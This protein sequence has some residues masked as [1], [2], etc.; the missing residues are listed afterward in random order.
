MSGLVLC[1]MHD[2]SFEYITGFLEYLKKQGKLNLLNEMTYHPYPPIP[3]ETYPLADRLRQVL[4]DYSPKITIKHG[5]TGCPAEFNK[6]GALAGHDWTEISQAKWLLRRMCGDY[7]NNIPTSVFTIIDYTYPETKS[8][9]HSYT[10][11]MGLLAKE[12]PIR[13][14]T[15]FS[16]VQ[17][18]V[19]ILNENWGNPGKPEYKIE[20]TTDSVK[21]EDLN[22]YQLSNKKSGKNMLMIWLGNQV[23]ENSLRKR[24][25]RITI[26]RLNFQKPVLLDLLNGEVYSV[27][28]KNYAMS[29]DSAV[30]I[31]IPV[32]DSPVIITENAEVNLKM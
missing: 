2:N 9:G 21:P 25:I 23:P 3:E 20:Q 8:Q 10:L 14:R 19:T 11:K 16:A 30:T 7:A 32:Y 18:A 28:N 6:S 27:S 17:N 24:M 15:S 13:K 29:A 31:N 1:G 26:N 5:E 12:S 4:K 22:L